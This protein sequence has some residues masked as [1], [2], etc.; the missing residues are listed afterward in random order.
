M[1]SQKYEKLI[2]IFSENQLN[3]EYTRKYFE[4]YQSVAKNSKSLSVQETYTKY[5]NK[6]K[7]IKIKM[8]TIH[9]LVSMDSL[10][11]DQEAQ[12]ITDCLKINQDWQE[13]S[14]FIH[15]FTHFIMTVIKD[16]PKM[17]AI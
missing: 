13:I 15:S 6:L 4:F 5:L 7:Q 14:Q 3:I 1:A 11:I 2:Q 16:F 17:E 9:N 8:E 10:T 12:V